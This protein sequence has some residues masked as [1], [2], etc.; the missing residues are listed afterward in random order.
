MSE[1]GILIFAGISAAFAVVAALAARRS[2]VAAED[3][4]SQAQDVERRNV[5]LEVHAAASEVAAEG[6]RIDSLLADLRQQFQTLFALSGQSASPEKIQGHMKE[7]EG[8]KQG[9][10][11]ELQEAAR[12]IVADTMLPSSSIGELTL[13]TATL[14]RG[15]VAVRIVRTELE[16]KVDELSTQNTARRQAK[17]AAPMPD[18]SSGV[19]PKK[20]S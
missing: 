12:Y 10:Q 9:I 11:S 6:M 14:R 8:K 3:S 18:R 19:N 13:A 20:I 17:F 16:R 5:L 4:A 2:A 15:V 1:L 7:W